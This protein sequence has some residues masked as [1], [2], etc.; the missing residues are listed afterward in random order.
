M[1]CNVEFEDEA[2]LAALDKLQEDAI[3]QRQSARTQREGMMHGTGPHSHQ[4]TASTYPCPSF[5]P[6]MTALGWTT[7]TLH[8]TSRGGERPHAMRPASSEGRELRRVLGCRALTSPRG[9]QRP[10]KKN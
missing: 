5:R 4:N 10:A 9:K 6:Q 1:D 8:T 2:F 3:A 7:A